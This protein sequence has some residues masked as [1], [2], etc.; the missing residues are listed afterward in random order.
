[1][2]R[3]K[4]EVKEI[5]ETKMKEDK[6]ENKL[7]ETKVEDQALEQKKE[8]IEIPVGKFF[9]NIRKNPWVLSTIVLV[10]ALAVLLFLKSGNSING[11]TVNEDVAAEKLLSFINSQ[12]RGTATLVSAEQE[13]SL[14]KVIVNYQNQDIPVFL[15]LDGNYLVA[16]RIPLI[17]NPPGNQPIVD[18]N[19]IVQVDVGDSPI[20]SNVS[21]QVTIVE[22]SDFQCPFC[23]RFYTQTLPQIKKEYLDTGKAK[24]V[25]K[26]FP[27]NNIHPEAQKAAGATRCVREQK[28]DSGYWKMHDKLFENQ[29][30]LSLENYKKWAREIGADG[31][32]FDKCLDENK[33]ADE[34]NDDLVYGESLGVQGTPGFFING[35]RVE[36]AQP[37]S[38]FKQIIDSQL[39][40]NSINSTSQIQ[41]ENF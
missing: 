29:Q 37:F 31:D 6:M 1:M 9:G 28:Q 19:E 7:E 32:K 11:N 23:A 30:S 16:D 22:F 14:Y 33:Y 12:G 13:G 38:V 21:A 27:L 10:I 34:V 40:T 41:N 39:N 36:G 35:I 15:T 26:D 24:L 4:K 18:E 2:A 20:L 5:Q 17:E 25:F 8:V 3:K